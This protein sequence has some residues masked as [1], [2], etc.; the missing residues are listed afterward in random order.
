MESH[1]IITVVSYLAVQRSRRTAGTQAAYLLSLVI[2]IV[3]NP[4]NLWKEVGLRE[5]MI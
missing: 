5:L 1:A 4:Y 3:L 2:T